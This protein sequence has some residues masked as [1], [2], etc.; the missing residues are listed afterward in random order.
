[1]RFAVELSEKGSDGFEDLV[2]RRTLNLGFL[3]LLWRASCCE[4]VGLRNLRG[5]SPG[6]AVRMMVMGFVAEFG[7]MAT[8]FTSRS[9]FF[10]VCL[11]SS[12]IREQQ[13]LAS[14]SILDVVPYIALPELDGKCEN[15]ICP[16]RTPDRVRG[17]SSGVWSGHEK[18]SLTL[19]SGTRVTPSSYKSTAIST[20]SPGTV[21]CGT[22]VEL[23]SS[24]LETDILSTVD[25]RFARFFRLSIEL[26]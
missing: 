9:W 5:Y 11:S 7:K 2:V 15:S 4:G 25:T 17:P 24:E 21:A 22:V 3:V 16:V 20:T 26:T 13:L 10:N 19:G 14:D 1:V 18:F 6:G 12:T 8:E 23:S